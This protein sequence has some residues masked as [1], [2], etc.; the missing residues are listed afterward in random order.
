MT[1]FCAACGGNPVAGSWTPLKPTTSAP[2][3]PRRKPPYTFLRE[4]MGQTSPKIFVR[5]AAGIEW[6]VKGGL[7]VKPET[8]IT[9]FVKALGYYA[10]T[11]YFFASGRIDGVPPL[12]R[13]WGFIKPDGSF[14][15]ASFEKIE[16]GARFVG[17]WSWTDPPYKGTR[18]LNGLK[19]LMMLF[20]NWD[21]KDSRDLKKGSNTSLIE[22][23][24]GRPLSVRERLGAITRRVGTIPGQAALE[25]P[26]V[27]GSDADV[28]RGSER[29][30][31]PVRLRR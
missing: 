7:D 20:S 15:W 11:T 22:L 28:C 13:A 10:E 30:S 17:S 6:R 16:P 31:R 25:L 5:D 3:R 29:G 19:V 23:S 14:T 21:N 2:L 18:E 12:K 24:D 1:A 4:D 8:F 26:G 27:R 9:R